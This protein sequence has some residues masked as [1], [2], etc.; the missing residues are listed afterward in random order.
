MDA[1]NN[2]W[3]WL[4][5][6]FAGG[7][8]AAALVG[9]VPWAAAVF[10]MIY[11]SIQI[12]ESKTCQH[13]LATRRARRIAT[14]RGAIAKLEAESRMVQTKKFAEIEVEKKLEDVL[15]QSSKTS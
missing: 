2:F 14:Y 4:G 10:G 8:I 5:H 13:W 12:Y 6:I 11:Y 1:W 15:S 7:S 3:S 9:V